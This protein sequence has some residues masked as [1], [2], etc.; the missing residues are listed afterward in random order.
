[1]SLSLAKSV[2][3]SVDAMLDEKE[4]RTREMDEQTTAAEG[5]L[6]SFVR[7]NLSAVPTDVLRRHLMDRERAEMEESGEVEVLNVVGRMP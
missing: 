7:A 4:E 3:S 2:Q 6:P 5:D 1:M